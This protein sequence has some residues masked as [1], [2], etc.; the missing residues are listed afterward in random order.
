MSKSKNRKNQFPIEFPSRNNGDTMSPIIDTLDNEI[1][2]REANR[3]S[4]MHIDSLNSISEVITTEI[5]PE[6]EEQTTHEQQK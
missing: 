4:G 1:F 6:T 3:R 2:P 5:T